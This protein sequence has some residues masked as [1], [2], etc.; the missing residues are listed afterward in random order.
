MMQSG[1]DS[2]SGDPRQVDP[3]REINDIFVDP[4]SVRGM[5]H[6]KK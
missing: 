4:R 1:G 6:T 2:R 3:A 5:S